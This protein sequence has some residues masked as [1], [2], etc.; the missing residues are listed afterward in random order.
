MRV[1]ST[2]PTVVVGPGLVGNADVR[3]T[4]N[5]EWSTSSG[6]L[7]TYKNSARNSDIII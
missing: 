3:G 6:K 7:R 1:E 5:N 2:T 4:E